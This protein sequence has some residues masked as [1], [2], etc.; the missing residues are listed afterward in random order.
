MYELA[1]VSSD[2]EGA[3]VV[4]AASGELELTARY[5]HTGALRLATVPACS[6][7]LCVALLLTTLCSSFR[8]YI[9]L[10]CV[11]RSSSQ[12]KHEEVRLLCSAAL[13]RLTRVARLDTL[14]LSLWCLDAGAP[15]CTLLVSRLDAHGCH[16][17]TSVTLPRL[18]AP[19]AASLCCCAQ[20][21]TNSVTQRS[22]T[23]FL[24]RLSSYSSPMRF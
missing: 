18:P 5:T 10:G 19:R 1:A 9:V 17:V 4:H 20:H 6:Y 3:S 2:H 8:V 13:L 14:L 12:L 23:L 22:S 15:S 21:A 7:P 24:A 11:S 16:D